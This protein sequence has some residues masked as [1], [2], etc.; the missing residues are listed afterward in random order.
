MDAS[1]KPKRKTG[2]TNSPKKPP[3]PDLHDHVRALEKAGPADPGRPADQQGHRDAPAGALAVPRRHRGEG[4]Q[5]VPVHQRHRQQGPQVRHPGAGRRAR[6]QPRDLPHRHRLRVRGDRR[7]L[8]ARPSQSPI[9]AAHRR[10][11]RRATRSS[12]PAKTSTSPATGLDGIPLPISTPGWDIAP[13]TTLSQY[14]T[15]DPDTGVQ[16]MGN[17]RGQVKA[18]RRLG[19]N[20]S[21]E[22]RPGIYNHWEKL[23]ERGFK[24]LPCAVVLGAPPV[25]H[26]RVGAEDPR[27][28]RRA[29]RRGR[30]GRRA[31]QRGEGEDRRPAG[32]GRGRD[33]DRGLHR[34]RVSRARGAVRRVARPRQ[35]A[36]VQRLHGRHRHHAAARRDPHLDHL[37]GDAV[38]NRA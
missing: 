30:A 6:R 11:T 34:H 37:A 17:Y 27:D 16:N 21:L 19:M 7:A 38:A 12:S 23:R 24:K 14:I 13:Y 20:P 35:P 10:R 1:T 9:A 29:A 36:G 3:Y 5:G 4:P 28:A 2:V 18:R 15:K 32:A 22:L 8:G 26:L 33:R 31:D 25:H